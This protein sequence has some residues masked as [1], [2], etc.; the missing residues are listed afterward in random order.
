MIFDLIFDCCSCC[1]CRFFFLAILSIFATEYIN[2]YMKIVC[3]PINKTFVPQIEDELDVV[4]YY[5][6]YPISFVAQALPAYDVFFVAFA[7]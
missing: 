4:P 1:C 7:S 6:M 3:H 2:G 5:A